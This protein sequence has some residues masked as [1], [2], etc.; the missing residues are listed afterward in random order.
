MKLSS[1]LLNC[2]QMVRKGNVAAD[3]GTDHGYLPIYLLETGIC[4]Q[5][6]ASDIREMPLEAAR[7]SVRRAGIDCGITFYLSDGLKNLPLD[8]FQTVICAGMG[9][10]CIL[11]IL[12]GMP[13]VWTPDYQFIIQPQSSANDLRKWLGEHGFL[14]QQERLAKDGKFVYT[15]MEVRYGGGAPVE[16]GYQYLSKALLESGDPL[17]KEYAARV[18][19]SL[20]QTNDGFR[21]AQ[22]AVDPE[23][24]AYY[25]VAFS[26]VKELE[27]QYGL[28]E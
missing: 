6:I 4:P 11:G 28:C 22:R 3:V 14:I 20:R 27:E 21:A 7:R 5:V 25:E 10:D 19:N 23:V 2:A 24:R 13:S 16:P 9:G 1:R 26:Q 12:E 17:L 18:H 15:V 8:E